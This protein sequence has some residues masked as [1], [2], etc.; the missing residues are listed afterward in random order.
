MATKTDNQSELR[1]VTTTVPSTESSTATGTAT[2]TTTA[3][4][5]E[6]TPSRGRPT[7]QGG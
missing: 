2:T 7:L 6:T 5:T 1:I 3:T 4:T